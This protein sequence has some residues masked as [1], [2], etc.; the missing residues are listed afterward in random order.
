MG[1]PSEIQLIDALIEREGG[2]VNNPADKGGPTR[3][4]VT[5]A[6]ARAYGY[7]GAMQAL[8]RDT[9]V[10]IYR[11]RYWLAPKLD[12]VATRYPAIAAE[13]FDIGVNMGVSVAGTF[14][15]RCLNVMNN[16]GQL[17]ADVSTDGGIGQLTLFALDCFRQRRGEDGGE[18]LLVAIRS[19]RGA[20][21]IAIGEDRPANETFEY[22]WF[23]RMVGMLKGA[24]S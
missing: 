24:L 8:P 10:Q 2:Y 17:Y 7:K 21:Y 16:Q 20:R 5:E 6:V 18:V 1:Q 23:A 13:L 3:F 14:L 15:Q 22:G 12:Q 11:Q 19:L 4:G 9:A